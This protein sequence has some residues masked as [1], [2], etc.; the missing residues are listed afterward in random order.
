MVQLLLL[1]PQHLSLHVGV[2]C[3]CAPTCTHCPGACC[4]LLAVHYVTAYVLQ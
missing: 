2:N 1:G 4:E 3:A